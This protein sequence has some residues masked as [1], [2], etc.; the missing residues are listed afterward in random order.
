[1]RLMTQHQPGHH[2]PTRRPP[3][4]H[5][6]SRSI[7]DAQRFASAAH[8]ALVGEIVEVGA[9]NLC[10]W[11][12]RFTEPL[13]AEMLA[14]DICGR[15]PAGT[16][17]WANDLEP[18]VATALTDALAARADG[19]ALAG[20]RALASG[21]SDVVA[22]IAGRA[23]ERL[24]D[25]G[26][27]DPPWWALRRTTRP[28]RSG[29]LVAPENRS[30]EVVLIEFERAA[31]PRHCIVA[32][33]A[34]GRGGVATSLDVTQDADALGRYCAGARI[35]PAVGLLP[36]GLGEARTRMVQA[37]R[38]AE[39]VGDPLRA[40]SYGWYR[41]LVQRRLELVGRELQRQHQLELELETRGRAA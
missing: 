39:T 20:L 8:L 40:A 21:G 35:G 12:P 5:A 30:T 11:V 27:L 9:E 38:R 2:L 14:S 31:G 4:Q 3:T 33:V 41:G 13:D 32:V 1:M 29:L 26:L 36:L 6:R 34:H 19:P 16:A 28:T 25:R 18:L 22:R 7:P 15:W 23:A 24:A 37:M 17:G 10:T